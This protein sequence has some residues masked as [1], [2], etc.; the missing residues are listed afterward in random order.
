MKHR[1]KAAVVSALA[2]P[3]LA[4]SATAASAGTSGHHGYEAF[5]I[6]QD[7]SMP[8]G[9]TVNM[10]GA[11]TGHRGLDNEKSD[12]MAAFEFRHGS[13]YVWHSSVPN[14][15]INPHTCAG[16]LRYS[17]YWKFTG[18]TGKYWGAKGHGRFWLHEYFKLM[19][20]HGKCDYN[21]NDAPAAFSLNVYA[22]GVA[23]R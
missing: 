10:W 18:G 9:G 12:T 2:V 23:S 15:K 1:I 8:N 17:G 22:Q 3:A 5:T 16:S 14:P 11:L 7:L 6:H 13:V 21:Q 4:L 20:K 19:K